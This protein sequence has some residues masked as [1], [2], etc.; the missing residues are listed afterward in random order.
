MANLLTHSN[1]LLQSGYLEVP[2]TSS[3]I[4]FLVIILIIVMVVVIGTLQS[5][6]TTLKKTTRR[7]YNKF[8]FD[9]M[10]KDMGL[11]KSQIHFL[12]KLIALANIRHPLLL[13]TNTALLDSVLK[14]GIYSIERQVNISDADR[15]KNLNNL[16]EIKQIIERHSR[17]NIGLKSTLLIKPGQELIL[18]SPKGER[19]HSKVI[20]NFTSSITCTYPVIPPGREN[21]ITKGNKLKIFFWREND[22][23]YSFITKVLSYDRT[24][25]VPCFSVQHSRQLKREQ[26]RKFSRKPLRRSCFLYPVEIVT[27]GRGRNI[28]RKLIVHD[29]QRHLGIIFDISVGGC[30]AG[31][32]IAFRKGSYL[33]LEFDIK[34]Q[35]PVVAYGKVQSIK[36]TIG[37]GATHSMHIQFVKLSNKNRNYIYSYV[38]NYI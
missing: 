34:P 30:R 7:K 21:L 37:V 17:K 13:F 9:R 1:I 29:N 23:G 11:Q 33:K 14:K 10:A 38:Y 16:Y 32:S 6:K 15:I 12:Q 28:R 8:L 36:R 22:S 35:T 24:R 27:I 3:I 5:R 4:I 2:D 25:S 31:S 19:F 26:H 20:S 18:I